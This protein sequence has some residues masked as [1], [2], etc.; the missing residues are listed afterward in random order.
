VIRAFND[1]VAKTDGLQ[2]VI[3]PLGDGCWFGVRR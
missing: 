1:L 3:V 2:A